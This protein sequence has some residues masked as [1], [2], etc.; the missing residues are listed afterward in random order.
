MS[1]VFLCIQSLTNIFW[2]KCVIQKKSWYILY[3]EM[4]HIFTYNYHNFSN[5]IL[6]IYFIFLF[7]CINFFVAFLIAHVLYF[8]SNVVYFQ[9]TYKVLVL[10]T[11][12]K[13][14]LGTQ[15]YWTCNQNHKLEICFSHKYCIIYLVPHFVCLMKFIIFLVAHVGR[16]VLYS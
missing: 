11:K 12:N 15:K 10:F 1:K 6:F 13:F 2:T 9:T 14:E 5:K 7:V 16:H 3:V 8:Q 4:H